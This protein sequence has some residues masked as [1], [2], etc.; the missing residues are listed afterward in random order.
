MPGMVAAWHASGTGSDGI[1]EPVLTSRTLPP[2]S[3]S[4]CYNARNFHS[5]WRHAT[6]ASTMRASIGR[7]VRR[8][9]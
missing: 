4:D 8:A 5:T 2:D 6:A 7:R 3:N 1:P 9:C